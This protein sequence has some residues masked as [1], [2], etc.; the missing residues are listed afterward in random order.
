MKPGEPWIRYGFLRADFPAHAHL[1]WELHL[2]IDGEARFTQSKREYRVGAG[3]LLL[4]PPG[5]SHA[6][7]V[8]NSFSFHYMRLDAH[9]DDQELLDCLAARQLCDGPLPVGKRGLDELAA[10]R[11]KLETP[12]QSTRTSGVLQFRSWLYGIDGALSQAMEAVPHD[13]IDRTVDY[14]RAHLDRRL[15]LDGLAA[16]AGLERTHYCRRFRQRLGLPPMAWFQR[17]RVEAASFLLVDQG[18]PLAEI[19]R[20]FAFSDEFHFSKV[21]RSWMGL[22]PGQFRA[23][24]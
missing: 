7:L 20:R 3:D 22:P 2:G 24:L 6:I 16:M 8:D 10:I 12:G 4:S 18:I 1:V 13:G 19:A 14:M 21:F 9:P 17:A 23:R 5:E 11:R 15:G